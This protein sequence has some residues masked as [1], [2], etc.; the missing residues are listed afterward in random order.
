MS[1]T[2]LCQSQRY[3]NHH[4]M[5][6]ISVCQSPHCVNHNGMLITTQC[7]SSLYVNHHIVSITTVCQSPLNANHLCMSIIAA[8]YDTVPASVSLKTTA[9]LC[10]IL[11]VCHIWN[12]Y[13]Y[14][15]IYHIIYRAKYPEYTDRGHSSYLK[16]LSEPIYP[17]LCKCTLN[18]QGKQHYG[19]M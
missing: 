3:V 12:K 18:L 2:T 11:K 19:F 17:W 1:I 14:I 15:I 6:I 8:C 13:K 9:A 16:Q 5:P 10:N 4:S 7:Q